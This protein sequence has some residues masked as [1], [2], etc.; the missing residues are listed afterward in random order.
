ML[1]RIF[2]LLN[3][4]LIILLLVMLLMVLVTLIFLTATKP[5]SHAPKIVPPRFEASPPPQEIT[6]TE[7]NY[8]EAQSQPFLGNKDAPGVLIITSEPEGITVLIDAPDDE[9]NPITE[10]LPHNVTPFKIN[11]F[12]SGKHNLIASKKG[13]NFSELDFSTN[14]NKVNRIHLKLTPLEKNIGY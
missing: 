13:Y 2:Q 12:P 4:P 11:S 6:T 3:N 7:L 5:T 8:P 14:A 9:Y 1:K 10:V